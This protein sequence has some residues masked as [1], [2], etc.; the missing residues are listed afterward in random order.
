MSEQGDS[1]PRRA[2]PPRDE[3]PEVGSPDEAAQ[4]GRRA[5]PESRASDEPGAPTSEATSAGPQASADR[6]R[7]FAD[8]TQ[9]PAPPQGPARA[10][11]PSDSQP[12]GP[13]RAGTRARDPHPAGLGRRRMILGVISVVVL[14]LLFGGVVLAQRAGLFGG[15]ATPEPTA[16]ATPT[17]DPV[18]TYLAQP[19]DLAGLAPGTWTTVATATKLETTTPQAKCLL[20]AAEQKQATA[21]T[22]VRTFAAGP[23]DG[24]VLHQV[25]RYETPATATEAYDA[26]LTQLGNCDRAPM[27]AQS[28]LSVTGLSDQAGGQVLVLQDATNEF[29]TLLL[30]RTGAR[31]NIVDATH[32][33]QPIPGEAIGAMLAAVGAR[34]CADGGTCPA[35]VAVTEAAPLPATPPGWLAAVDLPRLTLGSGTW[36][37]TDV[38]DTVSVPGTKCEAI[39]LAAMPGATKKQQRTYLLRDDTNAPQ[40]FGIDEAIFTFGSAEEAKATLSKVNENMEAC[41]SRAATATVTKTGDPVGGG[42]SSAW[43][44][45]QK[46]DQSAATASFRSAVAVSGT[47]MVYLLANPNQTFDFTNE[48][49][50]SV[51]SRAG[52]RLA[53]FG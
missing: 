19:G 17:I 52:Q 9:A 16:S 37:G 1:T 27:F 2:M 11:A 38:A 34:Q 10:A 4:V 22:M 14:A 12:Q 8:P 18:A 28:G 46:V 25:N 21:D 40:N 6:G 24:A 3:E 5:A 35:S 47:R 23:D 29:H 41:A 20:P 49:W 51:V 30:S 48:T 42:A 50:A 15:G 39:D 44:V 33:A 45:T 43:I 53:E 36:R 31:V 32:T 7:R 26:L 13:A